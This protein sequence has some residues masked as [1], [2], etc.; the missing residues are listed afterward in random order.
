MYVGVIVWR[1]H[2]RGD[3][4]PELQKKAEVYTDTLEEKIRKKLS[5]T[6]YILSAFMVLLSSISHPFFSKNNEVRR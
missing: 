6:A 5:D 2:F 3:S 4:A 1:Q